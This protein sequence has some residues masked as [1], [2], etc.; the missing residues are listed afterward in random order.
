[1][2]AASDPQ[3]AALSVREHRMVRSGFGIKEARAPMPS[4]LRAAGPRQR[5]PKASPSPPWRAAPSS[6]SKPR[7]ST[8]VPLPRQPLTCAIGVRCSSQCTAEASPWNN[9]PSPSSLRN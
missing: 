7:R 6:S 2:I 4:K 8:P 5:Y 1:M 9:G 3:Y